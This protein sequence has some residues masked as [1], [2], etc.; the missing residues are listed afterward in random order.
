MQYHG[1]SWCKTSQDF[2]HSFIQCCYSFLV[3]SLNQE[4]YLSSSLLDV[5]PCKIVKCTFFLIIICLATQFILS[6][7]KFKSRFPDSSHS[8]RLICVRFSHA[9]QIN[10]QRHCTVVRDLYLMS[11]YNRCPLHRESRNLRIVGTSR[12]ILAGYP[13]WGIVRRERT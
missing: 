9:S 11:V 8:L 3:K 5:S 4:R 6:R 12:P 7:I 10:T 13:F 1:G 2:I